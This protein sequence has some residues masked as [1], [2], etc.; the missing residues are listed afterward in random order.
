[1][2][3]KLSLSSGHIRHG[4]KV[5]LASVLAYYVTGLMNLPY[6]FWAVITTVIVMQMHVADSIHMCL[7]RF[8]GTAIGAIIGIIAI[9]IFPPTPIYTLI[10]IFLTTGLCAYLTRYNARFRM[11]AITVA[12]VF[13]TSFGAEDRVLYTLMR[14]VEIGIGVLCAFAVSMVVW[15]HRV[16]ATLRDRLA[17]QY[18]EL[19]DHYMLLMGNFVERQKKADPD[20]FFDLNGEAQKNREMFHK[21]YVMERRFFRDDVKLLSLQVT[22]LNSVL[23][24]LQSLPMLLNEVEGDGFDIIMAPELMELTRA[25]TEALRAIGS[26]SAHDTHRLAA[27]VSRIEE[28]F[29]ELRRQRVTERFKVR[30]FFQVLSF[31]NAS[32]HLGE[33]V[34]EVLNKPELARKK[35]GD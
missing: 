28:R 25:T 20:I 13:L 32:Q 21:V 1:M 33:Y 19:A 7:Y 10:G 4:I 34:L 18:E 30:R 16:S 3:L 8:T 11:A 27:A 31:I 26:G 24:R 14:V 35:N 12:I 15:P 22:V 9:M 6:G 17:A 23:E 2:Q 29:T 5:G